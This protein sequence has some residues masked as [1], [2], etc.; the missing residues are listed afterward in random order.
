MRFGSVRIRGKEALVIA[1]GDDHVVLAEEIDPTVS[2]MADLLAKEGQALARLCA[3]NVPGA[4]NC[5]PVDELDWLPVVP[6][7]GKIL[8]VAL[9]NSAVDQHLIFRSPV[10]AFFSK[11]VSSVQAHK[12]PIRLEPHYGLTHPEPEL[13]VILAK[14][15]RNIS[16]TEALDHV[17]GYTV[18]NDVTSVGM[19]NEDRFHARVPGP[20]G[21]PHTEEVLTYPARY[22]GCD[23]FCPIG[24]W[25]V[26]KDEV[27]DPDRLAIRCFVDDRLFFEDNTDQYTYRV[28]EAIF[29]ISAHLTLEAGDIICMGTGAKARS[30]RVS[31]NDAD[32]SSTGATVRIT[33][34]GLGTLENPI[35]RI[36]TA[37][38]RL[39]ISR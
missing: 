15:G 25:M 12:K 3:A 30:G 5:L 8:N 38:P 29:W 9:N 21:A 34:D 32:I 7:P 33:I 2:T 19:R 10:P 13:A 28:A 4:A 17:A 31:L 16:I 37:D 39:Q 1:A 23:T 14:G 22:K 35:E 11:P 6:R 36:V 20:P 24:P 27:V 18:V 26:T